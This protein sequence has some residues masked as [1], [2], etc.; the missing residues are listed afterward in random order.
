M[1]LEPARKILNF[2]PQDTWPEGIEEEMMNGV[3]L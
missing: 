3:K 2:E 1:D